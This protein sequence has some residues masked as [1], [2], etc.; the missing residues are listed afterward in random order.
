MIVPVKVAGHNAHSYHMIIHFGKHR[1]FVR[2]AGGQG[3]LYN[4][5]HLIKIIH[6]PVSDELT[7]N[8]GHYLAGIDILKRSVTF[9]KL[10]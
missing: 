4:I 7:K 2:L 5:Y 9:N 1:V 6:I 10:I 8:P 3:Q